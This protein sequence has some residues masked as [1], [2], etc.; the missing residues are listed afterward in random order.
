LGKVGKKQRLNLIYE[1]LLAFFGPSHWWPADTPF[2]VCVGAILT[3][4]TAWSNVEKALA[5]LKKENFLTVEKIG[6][7]NQDSLARMI[8]PSGYFNQKAARLKAFCEF[9]T[10]EHNGDL[11]NLFS[12]DMPQLRNTLLAQKGIGPE[13]ADSMIC[14]A[15]NMPIFVV[16]AYSKRIFS[17][18]KMVAEDASY[19]AIQKMFMDNLPVD[20]G[21]YN[22]YHALIVRL[23]GTYCK[24]SSPDCDHCPIFGI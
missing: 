9:I 3:Q 7:A 8:R 1:K 17:R 10:N 4:N 19:D 13:T 15:A 16:D 5:N 6:A 22:E 21:L 23:G 14:Y 18:K 11:Q 12:Q 2:E 24:K 20:A